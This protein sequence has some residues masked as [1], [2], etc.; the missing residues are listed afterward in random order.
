[1]STQTATRK[2]AR[3]P[4]TG[5]PISRRA[6]N[7]ALV[8][9]VVIALASMALSYV[10][11]AGLGVLMGWS[12]Q[13]SV[14]LPV[15]VDG[16]LIAATI[17]VVAKAEHPRRE[18]AYSWVVLSF[19]AVLSVVG[20]AAHAALTY[21]GAA[22]LAMVL[23]VQSLP[24]V[25]LLLST[26]LLVDL[27]R[28]AKPKAAKSAPVVVNEPKTDV[29]PDAPANAVAVTEPPARRSAAE[30]RA[31]VAEALAAEPDLS[32]RALA[33]RL[34]VGKSTIDRAVAALSEAV[35]A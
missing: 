9:T 30:L 5:S 21:S 18:L 10:G 27:T 16:L 19:A 6:R 29:A 11:L 14:L 33:E 8:L 25:V 2:P 12:P 24:P 35:A 1:M 26:H 7:A 32:R 15:L 17:A 34:G 23:T 4:R 3:K 31:A 20:N 13:L 22:P 28:A